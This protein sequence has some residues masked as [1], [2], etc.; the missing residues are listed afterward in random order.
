[1]SQIEHVAQNVAATGEESAAAG[2]ELSAPSEMLRR[3]KT[4]QS[5]I[6]DVSTMGRAVCAITAADWDSL[7]R[8]MVWDTRLRFEAARQ[9]AQSSKRVHDGEP[10]QVLNA[11]V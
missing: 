10:N 7:S 4:A 9:F 11:L 6:R 1:M 8:S 3:G 5:L 2:E